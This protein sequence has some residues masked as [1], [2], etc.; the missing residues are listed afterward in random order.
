MKSICERGPNGKKF[1]SLQ[2]FEVSFLLDLSIASL[3]GLEVSRSKLSLPTIES[4]MGGDNFN[5]ETFLK[6]DNRER[7]RLH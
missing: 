5:L 4:S 2:T 7:C 3:S 6:P 1:K